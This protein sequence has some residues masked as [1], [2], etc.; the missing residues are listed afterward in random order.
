MVEVGKSNIRVPVRIIRCA[1][2]S[3]RYKT[4]SIPKGIKALFCCPA[5][6][7][8]KGTTSRPGGKCKDGMKI[9]TVLYDTKKWTPAEAKAHAKSRFASKKSSRKYSVM[10]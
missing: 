6:N 5:R 2:G 10:Y 1:K 7:W 9:V 3:F 8:G 4:L